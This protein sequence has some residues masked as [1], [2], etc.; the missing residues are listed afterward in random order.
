MNSQPYG[1]TVRGLRHVLTSWIVRAAAWT[2]RRMP[3][4]RVPH[5]SRFLAGLLRLATG[6]RQVIAREN[7]HAALGDQ[8]SEAEVRRICRRSMRN[9][10]E[11]MLYL[12]RLPVTTAEQ[13]NQMVAFSGV[14][15]LERALAAGKGVLIVTAHFGNW[16]LLGARI[17]VAGYPLQAVARDAAHTATASVI[18]SARQSIGR[19]C[20]VVSRDD[21]R[22]MLRVLRENGVLL[23]LPDQHVAEGGIVADFLGRPAMTATGPA[24]LAVRTGCAVLPAFCVV[25]ADGTMSAEILPPLPVE[26]SG[27]RDHDIVVNT[28]MINDVI[29]EQIR[30]HPDQWLWFHRRWKTAQ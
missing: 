28:Q 7:I 22:G 15:H 27:D 8:L 12:L 24:N 11:S 4:S 17:V 26:N 14:E 3:A 5:L 16:E 23:I 19:G 30:A 13:L 21:V 2:V 10:V 25:N 29:A 9:L 18:N 6:K 1:F 20:G